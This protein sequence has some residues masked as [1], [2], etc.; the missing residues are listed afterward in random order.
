MGY[1]LENARTSINRLY[2]RHIE[3]FSEHD[4]TEVKLTTVDGKLRESR[5]FSQSGC[6][7]ASFFANTPNA[8]SFRA[9][10][11]EKLAEPA[12]DML[13]VDRDTLQ[14]AFDRA[15]LLQEAYLKANPDMARLARYQEMD[16]DLD[17][18]ARLMGISKDTLRHRLR[19][20]DRLGIAAYRPNPKFA[21]AGRLGS[22]ARQQKRAALEA[23]QSLGLEG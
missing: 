21:R 6:I 16:L 10:A 13:Q 22:L 23:Q 15:E 19:E 17:E 2:N 8:K 20:L 9:W 7:L 1:L 3:E 5:I 18:K 11:K 12:A 4:S 14:Y